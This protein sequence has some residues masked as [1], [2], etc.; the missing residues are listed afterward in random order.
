MKKYKDRYLKKISAGITIAYLSSAIICGA[1]GCTSS[2][3][4]D[5]LKEK[6]LDGD[7]SHEY[8]ISKVTEFNDREEKIF[9]FLGIGFGLTFI[10]DVSFGIA[11]INKEY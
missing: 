10:T 3:K 1:I 5:N 9:R 6:Y 4:K 2:I 7:I 8:Y 11:S